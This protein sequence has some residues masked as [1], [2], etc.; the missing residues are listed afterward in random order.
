MAAPNT[1][2]RIPVN[3]SKVPRRPETSDHHFT[4]SGELDILLRRSLTIEAVAQKLDEDPANIE[5]R[6]AAERT[7]YGIQD[8]AG[9]HIPAFQLVEDGLLPGLDQVIPRLDP[10]LHPVAFAQWFQKEN[11][12]LVD[13]E[14]KELSPK[15]WLRRGY[16]PTCVATL[17]AYIDFF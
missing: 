10:K 16:Q 15:E 5:E 1:I 17:A 6:L 2:E 3:S 8:A 4:P 11:C 13:A 12:D 9:W 7:L 14:G